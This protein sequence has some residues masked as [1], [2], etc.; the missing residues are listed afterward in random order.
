VPGAGLYQSSSG[1]DIHATVTSRSPLR[2]HTTWG[3]SHL[4]PTPRT[5]TILPEPSVILVMTGSPGGIAS[6]RNVIKNLLSYSTSAHRVEDDSSVLMSRSKSDWQGRGGSARDAS[7]PKRSPRLGRPYFSLPS[8]QILS[9]VQRTFAPPS[10]LVRVLEAGSG[11]QIRWAI[12]CNLS[13]RRPA[14]A[15]VEP[16]GCGEMYRRI[17]RTIASCTSGS[18]TV[19]Q[20]LSAARIN[21]PGGA[22]TEQRFR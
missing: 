4:P 13:L 15:R 12:R 19:V 1:A 18:L 5:N 3:Q 6:S 22:G 11:S 7:H 8:R 21:V 17:R 9:G 20:N 14:C 10:K 16:H 2:R